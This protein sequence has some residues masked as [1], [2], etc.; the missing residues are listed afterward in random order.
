MKK[1]LTVLAISGLLL[2]SACSDQSQNSAINDM[3]LSDVM[4]KL[5]AGFA[6]DEL[7]M[8]GE[9]TVVTAENV[10]WYLGLDSLD[11]KEALAREP[12]ISSVA[13]S[14]VLVRLNDGQDAEALKDE[15]RSSLDT[16][17]WI[18]VGVEKDDLIIE[19]NGN[20]LLV[21]IDGTGIGERIVEA[22]K[23]I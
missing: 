21:M 12:M 16:Y 2:L 3:A 18:C 8:M 11:F 10:T 13:H 23:G 20:V 14:V 7:P 17:K 15:I 4:D 1:L 9:P 22:F 5:Y 19:E 6:E